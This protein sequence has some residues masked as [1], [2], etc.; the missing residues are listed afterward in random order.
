M[1]FKQ[2]AFFAFLIILSATSC[3][4]E[5]EGCTD[6]AA[7]NYNADASVSTNTCTYQKR[8]TGEYNGLFDC[9]GSFA[10]VF[11]SVEMSVSEVAVKQN[12]NFII[13]SNIGPLPVQGEIFHP[14]SVKVD[15]IL[16]DIR[17]NPSDINST[18]SGDPVLSK[19]FIVGKL[20]I[21]SDNKILSG[22]LNL[23]LE[24]KEPI[25]VGIFSIP[26]GFKVSDTCGFTSTKK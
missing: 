10:G 20:G 9:K 17:I 19:A 22:T 6:T 7:D 3:K 24:T 12:L 8:F 13:Q 21:T 11:E 2:L 16:D 25:V 5:V 18:F 26:P 4:K 23:T 15:Q 14:D 1:N